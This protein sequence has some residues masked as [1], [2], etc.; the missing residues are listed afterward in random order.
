M[1]IV[2][3][4]MALGRVPHFLF[5]LALGSSVTWAHHHYYYGT[6]DWSVNGTADDIREDVTPT[7]CGILC[8]N[9]GC[10]AFTHPTSPRGQCSL[11]SNYTSIV[12]SSNIT[13]F[14]RDKN[15]CL[16]NESDCHAKASCEPDH[17][18]NYTCTC[19]DWYY[20]NGFD[21][22][23]ACELNTCF[24]DVACNVTFN[25]TLFV[26]GPC[27]FGFGGN[28]SYCV[29]LKCPPGYAG[30]GVTCGPDSDLDG[31]PN[32]ELPCVDPQ[33]R[34]DNCPVV[35]NADQGNV[36]GDGF[37]DVCDADADDDGLADSDDN[38]PLVHNPGQSDGDADGHGDDCD[39]CPNDSNPSQDDADGDGAGDV[40]DADADDDGIA[41][42]VDNCAEVANG[43][44]SDLD[45]DGVG[46]ACDNCPLTANA[47]QADGNA[48]LFGDACDDDVDTDA[49]AI[50]DS[51]DN[52]PST[53]NSDQG[54]IDKDGIG[55]V[56]D[57]DADND[58]VLNG[59]DNCIL[60]ANADQG[61]VNSDGVGDAC[62]Q[63]H[64]GD[65]HVDAIDTCP[66]SGALWHESLGTLQVVRLHSFKAPEWTFSA[67]GL[68]SY[69]SKY[70]DPTMALG[71]VRVSSVDLTFTIFVDSD[72]GDDFIG[73]TFSFHDHSSFYV[74]MWRQ[75]VE[76]SFSA[77]SDRGI[78]LKWVDSAQGPGSTL[79]SD[80][81]SD[82]SS[83]ETIVLWHNRFP[84]S[85]K[86][87]YGLKILHR[88][89]IGVI[90]VFLSSGK[91]LL[92]DS[93]NI[94]DNQLTGGRFGPF[95]FNQKNVMW[96]NLLY[97]CNGW[98]CLIMSGCGCVDVVNMINKDTPQD[99]EFINHTM[100]A[101]V[102]NYSNISH[103]IPWTVD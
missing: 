95:C 92:L 97:Y 85:K 24:P 81:W 64:D 30:D 62:S 82:D 86:L 2:L 68:Q 94:Y 101:Q 61:D 4:E 6:K 48:N 40:C 20:G 42:D 80:L 32:V 55:D 100:F 98:L 74:I 39:N 9:R 1:A 71:N 56:C 34:Q 3:R 12:S 90:R 31:I 11:Y 22:K 73:F 38:C 23:D 47:D 52:C 67:D 27:P 63:D 102:W 76:T 26:C 75:D 14:L 18:I 41:N 84:W 96:A 16:S 93:G 83:G 7:M 78:F 51:L 72:F 99:K 87:S 70:S 8:N 89:L 33:C 91:T 77:S 53:P 13:L 37:G 10:D 69:E 46:D 54:D 44:Q 29:K 103:H 28:G 66:K 65:G 79:R 45:G 43:D 15:K 49:D 19:T 25:E 17:G 35:P 36:D 21:C 60:V 59:D 5:V 57:D 58:G 88:P 50:L